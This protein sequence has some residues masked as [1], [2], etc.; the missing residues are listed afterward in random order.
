MTRV[1]RI[2]IVLL[3]MAMTDGAL[4]CGCTAPDSDPRTFRTHT[5]IQGELVPVLVRNV[6]GN[7]IF[8]GDVDLGP[9]KE[10]LA[11][12]FA[13]RQAGSTKP[14]IDLYR[15]N[16]SLF[17]VGSDQTPW[18]HQIVPYDD[19]AL[20]SQEVKG[21]FSAALKDWN[22][23]LAGKVTFKKRTNE[24][25][26]VTIRQVAG[27]TCTWRP[28]A[29][30]LL[31][32]TGYIGCARHELGHVL[33]LAHEHKR[34]DSDKFVRILWQNIKSDSCDQFE[35]LPARLSY[36][37]YDLNSTMHYFE[38]TARCRAGLKTL[39]AI[40][41]GKIGRKLDQIT[42]GDVAGALRAQRVQ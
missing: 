28:R 22:R 9:V 27:T 39:Q 34:S 4:G 17:S 8:G 37:P 25:R 3:G 16:P 26:Y 6:N 24:A 14:A 13:L 30:E 2:G 31:L 10:L 40:P 41:P 35:T 29:R 18:E 33:G 38:S 36:G 11:R 42:A 21:D 12:D 7:A 20:V 19:S 23:L 1:A 5:V 32:A 15:D